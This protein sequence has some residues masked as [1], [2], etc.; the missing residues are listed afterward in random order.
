M[1]YL[2]EGACGSKLAGCEKGMG[3]NMNYTIENEILSITISTRGAKLQ[4]ILERD[5]TEYLWQGDE[6]TGPDKAPNIFP[7]VARLTEGKYYYNGKYYEMPIHGFVKGS[8]LKVIYYTK[9]TIVFFMSNNTETRKMYPFMFSY[10]VRY[11]LDGKKLYIKYEVINQD[12]KTMY[13]GLG[14]H[15]EF[16]VPIEDFLQFEDYYMEF[17][18]KKDLM[19]VGISENNF[20]NGIDKPFSLRENKYLD[21]KHELFNN[22]V[23]ILKKM[24]K[25]ITLTSDLGRK[26]VVVSYPQMKY[27]GIWHKPKIKV[28]YVCIEPWTSLPSREG[29][30]EDITKQKDLISLEA[31]LSYTNTWSIAIL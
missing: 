20:V 18:D 31:G 17:Y 7:Y 5:G 19:R 15:P 21:L 23:I 9:E 11:K 3:I 22:D 12:D 10:L 6:N 26:G 2:R 13:F 29:I 1:N 24:S 27:L 28:N 25:S 16:R 30:T 14:G 4:S 8:E